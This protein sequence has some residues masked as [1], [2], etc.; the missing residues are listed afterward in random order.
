MTLRC[1]TNLKPTHYLKLR[2]TFKDPIIDEPKGS[3]DL[4]DIAE[5]SPTIPKP[6]E[7]DILD[8]E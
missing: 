1:G 3:K 8:K 2:V 7:L 4:L 6:I 5:N